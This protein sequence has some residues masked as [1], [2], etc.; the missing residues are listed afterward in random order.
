MR[1]SCVAGGNL[2]G[3]S[4]PDGRKTVLS[5]K[6]KQHWHSAG[7]TRRDCES[8]DSPR[9]IERVQLLLKGQPRGPALPE[10]LLDQT[11]W[12]KPNTCRTHP[13]ASSK[14][15]ESGEAKSSKTWH[16]L[17][18]LSDTISLTL[19]LCQFQIEVTILSLPTSQHFV[20]TREEMEEK[21]Y[22][23]PLLLKWWSLD[24]LQHHLGT[25]QKCRL[26]GLSNKRHLT[27]SLGDPEPQETLRSLTVNCETVHQEPDSWQATS[28]CLCSYVYMGTG[29]G[30][31]IQL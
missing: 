19:I 10:I 11:T 18:V 14:P 30:K 31:R 8:L 13:F 4:R 5:C 2:N 3:Q 20:R 9:R 26:S 17:P 15:K 21:V 6:G 24:E 16:A 27:R 1:S 7:P 23:K 29:F 12:K 28:L 22:H 25:R